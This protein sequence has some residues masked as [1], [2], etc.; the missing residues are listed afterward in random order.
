MQTESKS[1]SLGGAS[2]SLI[3]FQLPF[4]VPKS[5]FLKLFEAILAKSNQWRRENLGED[6]PE[7]TYPALTSENRRQALVLLHE[8]AHFW[9]AVGTTYGFHYMRA[10]MAQS[11][12]V[13]DLLLFLRE[14]GESKFKLPLRDMDGKN[15]PDAA[16]NRIEKIKDRWLCLETY[17][18]MLHGF[19]VDRKVDKDRF[20]NHVWPCALESIWEFDRKE[21]TLRL[22]AGDFALRLE[23]ATNVP[24]ITW[25]HP[26]YD[27]RFSGQAVMEAAALFQEILLSSVVLEDKDVE[28]YIQSRIGETPAY[29]MA[30]DQV[31]DAFRGSVSDPMFRTN[32]LRLVPML[33]DLALMGLC[34]PTY[35][36]PPSNLVKWQDVHPG[37]RFGLACKALKDIALKDLR[38]A[39]TYELIKRIC[40]KNSWITPEQLADWGHEHRKRFTENYPGLRQQGIQFASLNPTRDPIVRHFIAEELRGLYPDA[41]A[42]ALLG[43]GHLF[44]QFQPPFFNLSDES[45]V[46]S[47]W[48]GF[49]V[50]HKT[51]R[52]IFLGTAAELTSK[53]FLSLWPS[54]LGKELDHVIATII[55]NRI[56]FKR[57][58]FN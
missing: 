15:F 48:I 51:M 28:N 46:N 36:M 44:H 57:D 58:Q 40:E 22:P 10:T 3:H 26:T 17:K 41:F 29:V 47:E 24:D 49:V 42:Q 16:R 7:L 14:L 18:N 34:D 4:Q 32:M 20:Y 50:Y 39:P 33:F 5:E 27:L 53:S 1:S 38:D 19:Y 56:D 8:C 13:H 43:F 35:A 6:A 55:W 23:Y 25:V 21:A 37:F 11:F 54:Q 2:F 31:V 45:L 12:W 9:Q 30:Y 52:T